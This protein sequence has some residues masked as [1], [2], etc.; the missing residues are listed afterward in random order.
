MTNASKQLTLNDRKWCQ[1]SS[2]EQ[3]T[4]NSCQNRHVASL[5]CSIHWYLFS[6]FYKE[7]ICLIKHNKNSFKKTFSFMNFVVNS[8]F[9]D[10]W[11]DLTVN[12]NILLNLTSIDIKWRQIASFI[13]KFRQKPFFFTLLKNQNRQKMS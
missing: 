6:L 7:S 12:Y 13:V 5:I 10:L 1:M 2:I 9:D 11:R 3:I 8:T 4:V